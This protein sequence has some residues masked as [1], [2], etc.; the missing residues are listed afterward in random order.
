M[1]YA[2]TIVKKTK[3]GAREPQFAGDG[4]YIPRKRVRDYKPS[5]C[6]ILI[7]TMANGGSETRACMEM[8]IDYKTHQN[9]IM[10][11]DEYR[12]AYEYAKTAHDAYYDDLGRDMAEGKVQGNAT[13]YCGIMNNRAGWKD[14]QKAGTINIQQNNFGRLSDDELNKKIK[15]L[16]AKSGLIQEEKEINPLINNDEDPS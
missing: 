4:Q 2:E 6:N 11:V 5:F 1:P 15:A 16:A 12:D 9:W 13:V 7:K 8:G 10:T 14:N 3:K